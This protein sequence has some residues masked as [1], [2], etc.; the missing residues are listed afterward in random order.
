[1][2][3]FTLTAHRSAWVL[4]LPCSRNFPAEVTTTTVQFTCETKL[5]LLS[6]FDYD[7]TTQDCSF[8]LQPFYSTTGRLF[9]GGFV[10]RLD[11][12][13]CSKNK[14]SRERV[15]SKWEVNILK[16][17]MTAHSCFTMRIKPISAY[18]DTRIYHIIIF[19]HL[20]H[21]SVT[22]CGHLQGGVFSKAILQR[23]EPG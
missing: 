9:A 14:I 4:L 11:E 5:K 6:V 20:P 18:V 3:I 13:W 1:M 15:I 7:M 16:Y 2:F 19:V 8:K 22:F 10:G 12:T 23:Q 21:V 17:F